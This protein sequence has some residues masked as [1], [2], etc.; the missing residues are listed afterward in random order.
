MS[1]MFS[2]RGLRFKLI[3]P[4]VGAMT[5]AIILAIGFLVYAQNRGNTQLNHLISAAFNGTGNQIKA[6]MSSLSGQMSEKMAKMIESARKEITGSSRDALAKAGDAMIYRMDKNNENGANNQAKLLAQAAGPALQA[7]DIATLTALADTSKG[8]EDVLFV[9][10]A[11]SG[12]QPLASYINEAHDSL[13]PLLKASG[14]DAGKLLRSA[15]GEKRFLLVS[16]QIGDEDDPQGVV[17]LASDKSK[18]QAEHALLGAHFEKLTKQS[19]T[20]ITA[21]LSKEVKDMDGALAA[22]LHRIEEQTRKA[23]D[24]AI[25]DLSEKSRQVNSRIR[26]SFLTG[27]IVCL[28]LILFLLTWNARLILRLLGGEPSTM[29]EMARQIAAGNLDVVGEDDGGKKS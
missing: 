2:P 20:A 9:I 7:G 3:V 16:Q 6:D 26:F 25:V 8:N 13:A 15:M 1:N 14:K 28:G 24:T 10:I 5:L 12:R 17:Y 4:V 21:I 23:G 29:A 22:S 27:S 19:E 18:I 11:D